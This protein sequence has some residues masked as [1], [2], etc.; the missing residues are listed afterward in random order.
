MS[1][2]SQGLYPGA[3]QLLH[4]ADYASATSVEQTVIA[5]L[6][7]N[8]ADALTVVDTQAWPSGPVAFRPGHERFKDE[9]PPVVMV[10]GND[11][12][13][14]WFENGKTWGTFPAALRIE[15]GPL[16]DRGARDVVAVLL[17]ACRVALAA[18]QRFMSWTGERE[19]PEG[20]TERTLGVA[21]AQV[22]LK[23]P[24]GPPR[25]RKIV[26]AAEFTQA[27]VEATRRP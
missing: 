1:F 8:F 7:G 3:N 15:T 23:L 4:V 21:T 26:P 25:G 22:R 14:T 9:E 6:N 2:P 19:D 27:R 10:D 12:T 20:G 24:A 5:I 17:A 16:W 13:E 11:A 18:D